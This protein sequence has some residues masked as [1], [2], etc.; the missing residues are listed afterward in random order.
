MGDFDDELAA[1]R[2]ERPKP[3]THAP[4]AAFHD[5]L[6]AILSGGAEDEVGAADAVFWAAMD[7]WAD[8]RVSRYM[9]GAG[10]LA[11]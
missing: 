7:E 10:E 9:R 5:L 8:R 11:P 2:R 1:L 6:A 3:D 4:R